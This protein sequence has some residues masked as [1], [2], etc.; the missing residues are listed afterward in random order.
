MRFCPISCDFFIYW[1]K[2]KRT[3]F[4]NYPFMVGLDRC[5][6]I[7]NVIDN[8]PGRIYVPNKTKYR[9]L[10]VFNTITRINES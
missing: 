4:V 8:P 6:E 1:F 5:N 7:F 10:D 2:S 3:S 9:N